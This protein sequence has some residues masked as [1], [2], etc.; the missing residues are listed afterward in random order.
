MPSFWDE[1]VS[2]DRPFS[3]SSSSSSSSSSSEPPLKQY[4]L[5]FSESIRQSDG[6]SCAAYLE[7]EK[8]TQ[9]GN[10]LLDAAHAAAPS[11]SAEDL[12]NFLSRYRASSRYAT[13]QLAEQWEQV[14]SAH[15]LA[16]VHYRAGEV[17]RAFS[18]QSRALSALNAVLQNEVGR[19]IVTPL[20]R[21]ASDAGTLCRLA[22]GDAERRGLQDRFMLEL[23][24]SD[25]KSGGDFEGGDDESAGVSG[26]SGGGGGGVGGGGGRSSGFEAALME[27]FKFCATQKKASGTDAQGRPDFSQNRKVGA[28]AIATIFFR[29][30]FRLQKPRMCKAI[31]LQMKHDTWFT[32]E[33]EKNPFDASASPC[34]PPAQ[35]VAYKYYT[36]KLAMLEDN[37]PLANECLSFA[38]RFCP[39]SAATHR[40]RIL[41]LLLPVRLH[42]G[43][44][45][46]QQLLRE[47]DLEGVY[48]GVVRGVRLGDLR[49][50]RES[51]DN[52]LETFIRAGTYLLIEKLQPIVLRSLVKRCVRLLGG[53]TR[54]SLTQ[55]ASVCSSDA[56]G[57]RSFP[58]ASASELEFLLAALVSSE[59]V[60]GYIHHS[61]TNPVLVLAKKEP[62]P[63]IAK[64]RQRSGNDVVM[65]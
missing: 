48:G 10:S 22:R 47:H 49:S 65:A 44:L 12:A 28:V 21:I 46:S 36:G 6:D 57:H 14:I 8:Q 13:E 52:N 45:P 40:R 27:S 24:G 59:R 1:G 53:T 23:A 51:I 32:R 35:I 58:V 43:V 33:L 15:L 56:I 31:L 29:L 54:L 18:Q 9:F 63:K 55:V 38:L 20:L 41:E 2:I 17:L 26:V 19:W 11:D 37:Y 7:L 34:F 3:K 61:A 62:F 4:L 5:A 60:K 16:C 42:I 30:L 50:F 39:V 64:K 25:G